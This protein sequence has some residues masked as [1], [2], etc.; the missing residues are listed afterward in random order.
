MKRLFSKR[1]THNPILSCFSLSIFFITIT[2][3]TLASELNIY[4]HRQ[5]F[6]IN[7][8]IETYSKIYGTKVN[9][10]YASKGLAQRL[11]AEGARSPADVIL[12][13][14]IA[15]LHVY[16]DKNLLAPINSKILKTNIPTHLRDFK[17]RWFAF[18]KRARVIVTAKS[19]KDTSKIIT[20][21]DLADPR[22]KGRICSRPGSHVYNRA[23]VASLI[24]AVGS[25]AT[26]D[27]AK[28]LVQNLARRPQGNDRAQIK[29]IYEGQ[30]D[31]SIINHYYFHKLKNS[32]NSI[33]KDWARA[34]RLIFPNQNGRGTHIN[35]SGGG[36]AKHSKNKLE[37]I[38]F[39]EFLT[40]E[41][42]QKLYGTVNFEY[43]VNPKVVFL[44]ELAPKIGFIEDQM[45]ISRIAELAPKAQMIIDRVEW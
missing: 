2:T 8:F 18:S 12:T 27:W 13:V 9:V 17:D 38:R 41:V 31:I 43:P 22:W 7:P 36:V 23:F 24:H 16:A 28:A 37:A 30:C 3:A 20:Y 21:E 15:R 35:I 1:K 4:S 34:V 32:K 25:K 44:D 29:A 40:T 33:K 42:A 6:L 45:P 39:L 11:Q 5:P 26:E 14:D 10:V 19:A